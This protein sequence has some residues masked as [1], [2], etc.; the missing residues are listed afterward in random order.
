[1]GLVEVSLLIKTDSGDTKLIAVPM[2]GRAVWV[3]VWHYSQDNLNLYLLDTDHW[4]NSPED[5]LITDRLY[6]GDQSK[7]LKQ[8]IV[9]GIGGRRVIHE[10]R[11][12]PS[13][14]HLN[15]GHSA[16]LTCQLLADEI[17][18]G[19]SFDEA[20]K[21]VKSKVL[22]TNHTLVAAGNDVFPN[23]LITSHLSLYFEKMA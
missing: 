17:R 4:K 15:E 12:K 13:L 18:N 2:E 22:F 21:A 14:Y 10:E 23:E 3:Q 19:S 16:L 11:L 20:L 5:R 9:L 1:M 8:E 6:G 7:R